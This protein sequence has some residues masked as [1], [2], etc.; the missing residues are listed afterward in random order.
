MRYRIL[1][2]IGPVASK[3]TVKSLLL[4][5]LPCSCISPPL[6]SHLPPALPAAP[7]DLL[8]QGPRPVHQT[9][10]HV[11]PSVQDLHQPRAHG[12]HVRERGGE[13][14][15]GEGRCERGQMRV[16]E[17]EE[18]SKRSLVCM[19]VSCRSPLSS[20]PSVIL[21]E[22]SSPPASSLPPPCF[23]RCFLP[24]LRPSGSTR[25]SKWT[26]RT[27]SRCPSQSE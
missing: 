15:E 5:L 21:S 23:P 3:R 8:H 4:L 2:P 24:A 1:S 9:L 7:S 13:G 11:H 12:Y 18:V 16:V 19:C 6:P 27:R 14:R 20:P 17:E 10:S 22:F 26:R 25:R